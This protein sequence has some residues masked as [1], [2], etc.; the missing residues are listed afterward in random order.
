MNGETPLIELLTCY[1]KKQQSQPSF[2]FLPDEP[3]K[4]TELMQSAFSALAAESEELAQG[5]LCSLLACWLDETGCADIQKLVSD[6]YATHV[7][8]MMVTRTIARYFPHAGATHQLVV[9][10]RPC[11]GGPE[12]R[13]FFLACHDAEM[14]K[15]YRERIHGSFS[16]GE[17]GFD[18]R[19]NGIA[20]DGAEVFLL[21]R[22]TEE[23]VV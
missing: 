21:T 4:V 13:L 1:A 7:R 20:W 18:V 23:V 3:P 19:N 14:L 22:R 16:V 8:V 11:A 17:I 9:M 15:R 6:D 5:A 2:Y 12:R 10:A